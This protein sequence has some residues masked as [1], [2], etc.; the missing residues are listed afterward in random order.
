LYYKKYWPHILVF[1][2]LCAAIYYWWRKRQIKQSLPAPPVPEPSPHEW[3]LAA[4]D[5]LQERNLWQGG[6]VEEHYTMLTA[7]FREYLERRYGITALE[8][9]SE[10]IIHQL[11]FQKLEPSL[12]ADTEQLLSV[13]DLIKFAKAD[14]GTD[15]HAA[16]IDRV[17]HF[18]KETM[19]IPQETEINNSTEQNETVE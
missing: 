19:H 12:L 10:E 11:T 8:Q 4:L 16:T 17:R 18:V 2:G 7:I 5:E 3:A 6:D 14:P 1:L 15:I 13:S 9:T